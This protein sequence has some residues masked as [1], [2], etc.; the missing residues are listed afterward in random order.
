MLEYSHHRLFCT[1]NIPT[2]SFSSLLTGV[3]LCLQQWSSGNKNGIFSFYCWITYGYFC[4]N[5]HQK[6]LFRVVLYPMICYFWQVFKHS[7]TRSH[8]LAKC[9]NWEIV[10][11]LQQPC[12]WE[13]HLRVSAT[14][15]VY[16]HKVQHHLHEPF[17]HFWKVNLQR[18]F[19][20][21]PCSLKS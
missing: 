8:P 20:K 2:Y 12:S 10:N 6:G 15:N 7:Q 9:N 21:W 14:R 19:M 5:C 13:Y 11:T 16:I 18:C 4:I 3:F 1:G 17:V